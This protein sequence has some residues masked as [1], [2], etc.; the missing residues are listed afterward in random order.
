VWNSTV[1]ERGRERESLKEGKEE[2]ENNF[3]K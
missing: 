2:K 3:K 1:K